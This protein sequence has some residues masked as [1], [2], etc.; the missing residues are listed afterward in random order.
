MLTRGH[1]SKKE[2]EKIGLINTL[3]YCVFVFFVKFH[4]QKSR[5]RETPNLSTDA[6]RS[7]NIFVFADVK[8]GAE[9]AK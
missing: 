7:T 5:I 3:I 4:K 8:N 9:T 6:D 1:G 2:E